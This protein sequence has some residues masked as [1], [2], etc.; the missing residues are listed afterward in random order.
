M[1][2][3]FW[4]RTTVVSVRALVALSLGVLT[5]GCGGGGGGGS[6]APAGPTPAQQSTVQEPDGLTFSVSEDKAVAAMGEP[7]TLHI[8][9]ANKTPATITGT[10]AGNSYGFTT[11]DPLLFENSI[12]FDS[13]GHDIGTDGNTTLPA[14]KGDRV[15]LTLAP[16]QSFVATLVYT[17]TRADTYTV[18]PAVSNLMYQ[19]FSAVNYKNA[20]PLTIT[21]IGVQS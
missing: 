2:V 9:L 15:P 11:L 6:S 4:D 17:F 3:K 12:V 8:V 19:S 14:S 1:V 10:F 7:V 16:G 13:E 21:V 5:C 20:G 18:S